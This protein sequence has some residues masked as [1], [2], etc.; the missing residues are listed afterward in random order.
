M[1]YEK[2][3]VSKELREVILNVSEEELKIKIK[4]I[5]WSRRNQITSLSVKWDSE[6]NT[7]FDG[8]GYIRECLKLMIVE[9]PWGATTDVFLSQV[10]DELGSVLEN[11]VPKAFS[12]KTKSI[13]PEE[14]KKES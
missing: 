7:V 12:N 5:P 13:G 1:S 11:L 14:V 6:G 2:F 8:D 9:A 3:L 10:G 4:D